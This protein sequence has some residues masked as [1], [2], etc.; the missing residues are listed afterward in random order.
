MNRTAVVVCDAC[1]VVHEEATEKIGILQE[2]VTNL[3]IEVSR[4]Q[5][6]VNRLRNESMGQRPPE[7]D[8][9]M[10]VA[11]YWKQN[12]SPTA[13][14]LNGPRMENT[15]ARIRAGYSVEEL[16]WAVWG[17]RC[18][19]NVLDGKRVPARLG[20]RRYVDLEL[21]MRDEK[22]VQIGMEIADAESRHDQGLLDDKASRHVAELCECNHARWS[23]GLLWLQGHESCYED[24]C[25]C[26][27]YDSLHVEQEEPR[28]QIPRRRREPVVP[29]EGG[30][31]VD[32]QETL[33]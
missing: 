4:K 23:H 20:G 25:R 22:H 27:G 6:R 26:Q 15:I 2:A 28:S 18:R 32:T 19:P 21:I 12:I 14:E 7:Y 1:G 8:D 24:G 33:L 3:G 9:A 29:V 5:A 17:Y 10:Q 16:K 13:R 11:L 30:I 31:N